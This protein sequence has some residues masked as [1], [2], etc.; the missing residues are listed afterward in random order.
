MS[1][2]ACKAKKEIQC[3]PYEHRIFGTD[4][5]GG[6]KNGEQSSSAEGAP[7]EGKGKARSKGE[8]GRTEHGGEEKKTTTAQHWPDIT[9][10]SVRKLINVYETNK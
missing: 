10:C 3:L 5:E 9:G 7:K 8:Q 6:K 2:F 1:H 4:Q